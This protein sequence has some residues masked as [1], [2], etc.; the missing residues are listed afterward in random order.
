[1][2]K[3]SFAVITL[4]TL[5]FHGT[6]AQTSSSTSTVDIPAYALL[7]FTG[8]ASLTMPF[9]AASIPGAE[10]VAPADN[11][12]LW[13]NYSSV[14]ST[15]I[16]LYTIKVKISALI[17]GVDIRLTAANPD[18]TTGSGTGGTGSAAQVI[19]ATDQPI[20]TGIG[21]C[22]TGSGSGAGS[23]LTYAISVNKTAYASLFKSAP[24]VTVTYTMAE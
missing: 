9:V 15:A 12:T 6:F 7:G 21:S 22:Q 23:N 16:S 14:T 5:G 10:I 11:S 17:P 13:L 18:M 24:V 4:L 3:L 20:V 1:M 8:A 19:T 2:K